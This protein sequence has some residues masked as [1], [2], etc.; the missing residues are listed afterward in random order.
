[1]GIVGG[2]IEGVDDP[3]IGGRQLRHRGLFS[4]D[5]VPGKGLFNNL[6]DP[7]LAPSV[8]LGDEVDRAFELYPLVFA[9]PVFLNPARLSNCLDG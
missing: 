3:P 9:Q 8:H 6:D 4:Q 2:P 5:V 7:L 1:M